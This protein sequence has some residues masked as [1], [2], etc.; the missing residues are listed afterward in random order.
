ML[1]ANTTIQGVEY[2]LAT[3]LRVAY[4]LQGQH[5]HKAYSEIF[6][7]M[8]EM[9][10]EKQIGFLYCAFKVANPNASIDQNAFLNYYLDNFTLKQVMQ[11]VG[12][13]I[14]G[15][16]GADDTDDEQPEQSSDSSDQGN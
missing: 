10:L 13:V 9:P 15:I 3:T 2:P 4:M 14:K 11:Q 12:Q 16:T 7:E 1:N 6:S 5:N 8:A